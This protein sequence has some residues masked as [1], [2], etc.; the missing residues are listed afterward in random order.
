M[1]TVESG[2]RFTKVK[3]APRI[4]ASFDY[5]TGDRD[6]E[7][8]QLNTFDPLYPLA[9]SFFGFHAAFE[10]KNLMIY[11]TKLELNLRKDTFFKATYWPG[12]YRAQAADGAYDS[13]GNIARRPEPQSKGGSTLDLDVAS[14]HIGS[15]MDV[16]VAYIPS[17]HFLFYATFLH[18]WPGDSIAQT[19]TTPK[20]PMNGV[21]TLVQFNF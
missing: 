19:Q 16:G 18:F 8:T 2:Y 3:F 14:K 7:D 15:Q 10:R 20:H 5:A 12:I 21:M 1:A 17:R 9:W 13:F 6:Q 11:G 4:S